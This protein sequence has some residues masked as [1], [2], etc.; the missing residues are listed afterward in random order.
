MNCWIRV[1]MISMIVISSFYV[2]IIFMIDSCGVFCL[3]IMVFGFFSI[4]CM[5]WFSIQIIVMCD[6]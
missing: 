1:E 3:L 5:I 4:I 2:M 6:M